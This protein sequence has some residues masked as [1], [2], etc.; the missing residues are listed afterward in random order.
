MEKMA[1]W[2]R[3]VDKTGDKISSLDWQYFR[4]FKQKKTIND[5]LYRLIEIIDIVIRFS[6]I[7][8]SPTK[9]NYGCSNIA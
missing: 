3:I 2:E 9:Y 7:S 4:Y 6:A 5:Y 8:S 1:A